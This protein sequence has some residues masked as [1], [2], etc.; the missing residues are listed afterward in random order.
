MRVPTG[1]AQTTMSAPP[2]NAQRS[3]GVQAAS[4]AHYGYKYLCGYFLNRRPYRDTVNAASNTSQVRNKFKL[5]VLY[6]R[7]PWARG[8]SDADNSDELGNRATKP[9]DRYG[10]GG[11]WVLP[12]RWSGLLGTARRWL[13][14]RFCKLTRR[15]V[16]GWDSRKTMRH[17]VIQDDS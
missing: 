5:I 17:P 13:Q 4:T 12:F 7:N 1:T 16:R 15:M 11:S 9:S 3:S 2:Q 10:P 14:H 8:P 6:D